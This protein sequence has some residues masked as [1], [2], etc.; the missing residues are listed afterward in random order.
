MGRSQKTANA[1]LGKP[2]YNRMMQIKGSQKKPCT[3]SKRQFSVQK[4]P[5]LRLP[6]LQDLVSI[7]KNSLFFLKRQI[8]YLC[9]R[10]V[11]PKKYVI[12]KRPFIS[13][14][15]T[16]SLQNYLHFLSL[17]KYRFFLQKDRS[18]ILILGAT[19]KL[20]S[21]RNLTNVSS[22]YNSY[23]QMVCIGSF[24][25]YTELCFHFRPTCTTV[26]SCLH[27]PTYYR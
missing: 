13:P 7:S 10:H 1:N 26:G 8:F 3:L 23:L 14:K 18:K 22:L 25:S 24:V 5:I 9:K 15:N 11:S 17:R 27:V 4:R 19:L 6:F 12:I 20:H 21:N 2:N 16:G